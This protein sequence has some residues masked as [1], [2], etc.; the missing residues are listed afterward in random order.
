M[1]TLKPLGQTQY[2]QRKPPLGSHQEPLGGRLPLGA[3]ENTWQTIFPV[4]HLAL[5]EQEQSETANW[6][7]QGNEVFWNTPDADS[8]IQRQTLPELLQDNQ[9][10]Q[11]IQDSS[12]AEV[13][14]RPRTDTSMTDAASADTA[15]S[16][17]LPSPES[18]LTT[19][20]GSALAADPEMLNSLESGETN[21]PEEN[22]QSPQLQPLLNEVAEEALSV[23][24]DLLMRSDNADISASSL[25]TDRAATSPNIPIQIDEQRN[26]ELSSSTHEPFSISRNVASDLIDASQQV[27][28]DEIDIDRTNSTL[29]EDSTLSEI[30]ERGVQEDTSEINANSNQSLDTE[31]RSTTSISDTLSSDTN[32][33]ATNA[34]SVSAHP[35][36]A[37][38]FDSEPE[39]TSESDASAVQN[40]PVQ[41]Q[42][43]W[44]EAVL[45]PSLALS[46]E[47][48][49]GNLTDSSINPPELKRSTTDSFNFASENKTL[50]EFQDTPLE[51]ESEGFA[52]SKHGT[53]IE[54][55]S[56]SNPNPETPNLN[57]E[58]SSTLNSDVETQN[59]AD[60][61]ES[62]IQP[63]FAPP[64]TLSSNDY[65]IETA[66]SRSDAAVS[67]NT[68]DNRFLN[69]F[70]DSEPSIENLANRNLDFSPVEESPIVV[71]SPDN[72]APQIEREHGIDDGKV[73]SPFQN[74]TIPE[75][76][77]QSSDLTIA[78]LSQ[79]EAPDYQ[80]NPSQKASP[81]LV[82][83]SSP[84]QS[85]S[86]FP[87]DTDVDSENF[88]ADIFFQDNLAS[89]DS[90]PLAQRQLIQLQPI[91]EPK[92]LIHEPILSTFPEQTEPE[93]LQQKLVSEGSPQQDLPAHQV[94]DPQITSDHRLTQPEDAA[95][96]FPESWSSLDELVQRSPQSR[97][98]DSWHDV[99][100]NLNALAS[101]S[102]VEDSSS[103]ILKIDSSSMTHQ[104]NIQIDDIAI[105]DSS[106]VI[107]PKSSETESSAFNN[108]FNNETSNK[109][110]GK[111]EITEEDL[112]RM[113]YVIYP[114]LQQKLL[115]EQ[116]RRFG[117]V[118]TFAF[119]SS[120]TPPEQAKPPPDRPHQAGII[121]SQL[122]YDAKLVKLSD[123]VYSQLRS[124]LQLDY[125]RFGSRNF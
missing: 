71:E 93:S 109:S 32:L 28:N 16:E 117:N 11:S 47:Y 19:E 56:T 18:S 105:N 49:F 53:E 113:A 73:Q 95:D 67:Q 35:I 98:P 91:A 15:I 44:E 3:P 2:L 13:D 112:E 12:P 20:Q 75:L 77:T 120:V 79:D 40:L 21:L 26:L 80:E 23:P 99:V 102:E 58:I 90:P 52:V 70:D 87:T 69:H 123:E 107:Q 101:H 4:F 38:N 48:E 10:E 60:A 106:P 55:S 125:E 124:R 122:L 97:E 57:I 14:T 51:T 7:E 22:I 103:H 43:N 25:A 50:Q 104:D 42:T 100:M 5:K 114:L 83:K 85:P 121:D 115:Q 94:N 6:Q 1:K 74:D 41:A 92:I 29:P 78:P 46:S 72:A 111:Q 62:I 31:T 68:I 96:D 8:S 108:V 61:S 86:T 88:A 84:E 116:E 82:Q 39:I 24:S 118:S 65:Q 54:L 66:A 9:P 89:I 110:D 30:P 34:D 17:I 59:L 64:T 27:S 63:S 45:P 33:A 36:E 76:Q 81:D 37:T 119:W